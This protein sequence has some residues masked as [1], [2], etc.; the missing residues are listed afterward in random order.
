MHK[1]KKT[2]CKD[3]GSFLAKTEVDLTETFLVIRVFPCTKFTA[4]FQEN[5]CS[6]S[7]SY[8]AI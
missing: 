1:G 4:D 8:Q 3:V 7:I 6:Q 2:K 5:C